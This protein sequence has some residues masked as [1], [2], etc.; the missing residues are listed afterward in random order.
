M[1]SGDYI[2]REVSGGAHFEVLNY[3][4]AQAPDRFPALEARHLNDGHWWLVRTWD[5]TIVGFAGLVEM[6]PFEATGYLKRAYVTPEHRGNGLQVKLM[7]LREAKARELGWRALVSEC[8]GD[9]SVSAGNFIK[10]GF[11]VVDPEQKWG[12][13][14]SIY[15]VKRL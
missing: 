2:I 3:L 9:N 4:N 12:A 5:R 1:I 11:T 15:F 10:C 14:G 13:P 7:K 6:F 8:A